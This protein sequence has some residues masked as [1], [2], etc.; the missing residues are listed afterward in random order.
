MS[1]REK[2]EKYVPYDEQE[3]RDKEQILKFMDTLFR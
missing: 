2:I 3:E 1:L